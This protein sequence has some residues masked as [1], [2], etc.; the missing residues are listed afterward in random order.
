MVR[1]VDEFAGSY[2]VHVPCGQGDEWVGFEIHKVEG[3]LRDL[4]NGAVPHQV[5]V[6]RGVQYVGLTVHST[7]KHTDSNVKIRAEPLIAVQSQ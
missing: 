5:R 3:D 7:C 6:R 4:G 2:D 1:P